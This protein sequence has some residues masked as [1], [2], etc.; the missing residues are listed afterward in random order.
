MR[1]V[2]NAICPLVLVFMPGAIC[3]CAVSL[4]VV[5]MPGAWIIRGAICFNP[6]AVHPIRKEN[7]ECKWKYKRTN[8]NVSVSRGK[9]PVFD[10]LHSPQ[11]IGEISV[12]M[13]C[14]RRI[15]AICQS[16]FVKVT[17]CSKL[18]VAPI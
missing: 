2:E 5:Y 3:N 10:F 11:S 17:F 4:L 6:R 15:F 7:E 9:Y 8:A 12:Q 18:N 16:F 1:T 14:H 13:H